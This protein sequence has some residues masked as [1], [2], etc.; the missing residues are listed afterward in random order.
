MQYITDG[1]MDL[2]R[3]VASGHACED[4]DELERRLTPMGRHKQPSREMPK[5]KT[6]DFP[7]GKS[8]S[9]RRRE[10]KPKSSMVVPWR[11]EKEGYL[12]NRPSMSSSKTGESSKSRTDRS[13]VC[14][15]CLKTG[16]YANACNLPKSKENERVNRELIRKERRGEA[17]AATSV[18]EPEE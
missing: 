9:V 2:F 4:I 14:Y 10:T 1:L 5:L 3:D 13:V 18:A 11:K 15:N 7:E 17:R 8:R 6:S 12:D 16:H